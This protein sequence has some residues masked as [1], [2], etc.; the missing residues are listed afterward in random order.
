MPSGLIYKMINI[1][2]PINGGYNPETPLGILEGN[3]QL[4]NELTIF[5]PATSST[6]NYLDKF[7][8]FVNKF[9]AD[10]NTNFNN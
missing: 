9:C 2:N 7:I 3:W 5:A 4:C 10:C 8:N 1:S 6:V